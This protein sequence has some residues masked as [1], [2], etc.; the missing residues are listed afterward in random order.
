MIL[1]YNLQFFAKDGPGGEKT[2]PATHKKLSDARKEGQV[3]KSREIA[4]GLGLLALFLVLKFWIGNMGL[5]FIEVFSY[6]YNK[7]PEMT[8]LI[9]G[10]A[11]ENGMMILFRHSLLKILIIIAPI[12]IIGFTVAFFSD[13][14]QVK[15][16][17]TSRPLMPKLSKLD[18]V[19]GF[20]KILSTN[21]LIELV[22]SLLKISIIAYIAYDFL[23]D[24]IDVI[25]LFYDME[26]LPVIQTLGKLVTDMGIKISV[27]YMIFAFADYLYQKWKFKEDMR[28]T[29]QEVKEEYKN[30][31]GDP[32]I[33]SKIRQKMMEA[34]RRRMMQDL[35]KADVVITNP[36]H[37]AVAIKYD[38][39]SNR[40]PIVI[41]KGADY[42][43]LQIREKA[44]EHHIEYE[45]KSLFF[46]NKELISALKKGILYSV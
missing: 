27:V 24:E 43:A 40:A 7:I 34:S 44:K 35:P 4:N 19:K 13:L 31:E 36:T 14:F 38:A 22:K 11:P 41:A 46:Y 21:S 6:V 45:E 15:W 28:M 20:K 29:K 5:N 25:F 17:P 30:Q 37:Y 18:P 32:Q 1:E 16:R 10:A 2:E 33:K 12:F 8:N 23:I 39:E 42:L 3:A 26:I 9:G